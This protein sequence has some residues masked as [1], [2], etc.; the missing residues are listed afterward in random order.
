MSLIFVARTTSQKIP[1]EYIAIIRD[2]S[3]LITQASSRHH[4]HSDSQPQ[5]KPH[6]DRNRRGCIDGPM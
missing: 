3:V 4:K 6:F 1:R 5:S 2:T